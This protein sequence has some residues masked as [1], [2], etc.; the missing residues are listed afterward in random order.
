MPPIGFTPCEGGGSPP[1]HNHL[2]TQGTLSNNKPPG[3]LAPAARNFDVP[4]ALE[5]IKGTAKTSATGLAPH[6]APHLGIAQA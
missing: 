2:Y 3:D 6:F 5:L 4:H 1:T